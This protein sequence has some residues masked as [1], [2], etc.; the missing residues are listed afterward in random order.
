MKILVVDDTPLVLRK[1]SHYL[2]QRGIKSVTAN[3]GQEALDILKRDQHIDF[4]LTDLMMPEMDGIDLFK[5]AQRIDRIQ[6]EGTAEPP[7]FIL[8]T[9]ARPDNTLQSGIGQQLQ[10]AMDIG[11]VAIIHKP[12]NYDEL[13]ALLQSTG[14][15]AV[16]EKTEEKT[17][18][19]ESPGE[20][21][22]EH[23]QEELAEEA[24]TP[25]MIEKL[26]ERMT[27]I[28][29]RHRKHS[30][31]IRGLERRVEKLRQ[32][33]GQ[34]HELVAGS[35]SNPAPSESPEEQQSD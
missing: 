27:R 24:V 28:D 23:P 17:E 11:F 5:A 9:A 30:H 12:F 2:E 21:A 6:D 15:S 35:P 32:D 26:E 13:L 22:G 33:M 31:A 29:R 14:G 25:K 18:K 1:V 4:V 16:D 7:K 3:S 19:T 20:T 10:E 8:M 34:I